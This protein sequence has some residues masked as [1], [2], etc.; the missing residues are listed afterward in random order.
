MAVFETERRAITDGESTSCAGGCGCSPRRSWR[1]KVNEL[2]GVVK[3]ERDPERRLTNRIAIGIDGG[4]QAS[5]RSGCRSRESATTRTSHP[6]IASLGRSEVSWIFAL[7]EA[8]V[9]TLRSSRSPT[10]R[11]V[12]LSARQSPRPTPT[13]ASTGS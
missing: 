9:E 10:R 1:R 8:E 5:G 11:I 13:T 7:L 2:T 6:G 12:P 4:T 3:G